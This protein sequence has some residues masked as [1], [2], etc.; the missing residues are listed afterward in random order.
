MSD[1]QGPG[2]EPTSTGAPWWSR[3]G[4]DPWAPPARGSGPP[5]PPPPSEQTAGG[6]TA[7]ESYDPW[8]GPGPLGQRA[9]D[10]QR[11]RTGSLVAGMTA[12]ALLVGGTAGGVAGYVA[13]REDT[14]RTDDSVS[15][16]TVPEGKVDRAPDSIAGIAAR[17]SPGV[18]K[19]SVEDG[20]DEGTGTGFVID[21]RGYI[22]TNNH[23]V[24]SGND[25]REI[26]VQ[27]ADK[28]TAQAHVVGRDASYDLAV[29]KVDGMTGLVK[30]ALGNSDAIAVGDPVIAIGSPL[31]L[32]GTVTSGIISAQNRTVTT[33][34]AEGE[35]SFIN[36]IQTD[37]AINPGNS[38]GPLV[39]ARGEVVGVNTAIATLGRNPVLGGQA[40]SIGLGFA[41]PMNIARRAAEQLIN[42]GQA[43]H[44]IIGASLDPTYTGK[45]AKILDQPTGGNAP[46][47]AGG[48]AE[49][50]GIKPGDVVITFNGQ[51]VAGPDDLIVAI[52]SRVPGERVELTIRRGDQELKIPVVLGE[53]TG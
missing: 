27:F 13:G 43:S 23:V 20:G 48:P 29:I 6:H 45:G 25:D 19:I 9:D 28:R 21:T 11:R 38:G 14:V 31:G 17:V 37:A 52:R 50:A 44:P 10:G 46:I 35:T 49:K 47:L 41:I 15:L 3:P 24:A 4:D 8:T 39:N 12:L 36:A 1:Q 7:P 26:G 16:G 2:G 5:G 33:G 42:S 18:V 53:S 32:E 22:L 34:Q 30:L 40:G 51:P